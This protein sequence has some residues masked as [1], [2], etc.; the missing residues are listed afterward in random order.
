MTFNTSN[1]FPFVILFVY[2]S[3]LHKSFCQKPNCI[4]WI[5]FSVIFA[6][7]CAVFIWKI[8]QLLWLHHKIRK[9]L[10]R[11]LLSSH[12]CHSISTSLHF[13]SNMSRISTSWMSS[14]LTSQHCEFKM[15]R[16]QN[17]FCELLLNLLADLTNSIQNEAESSLCIQPTFLSR[18]SFEHAIDK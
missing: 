17:Q 1:F 3:T 11:I 16:H 14:V 6:I 18:N 5:L 4:C 15:K 2:T 9:F 13:F 12:L 10:S 7:L 8:S